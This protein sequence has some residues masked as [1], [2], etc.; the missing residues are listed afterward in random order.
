MLILVF[1]FLNVLL[2]IGIMYYDSTYVHMEKIYMQIGV[3]EKVGINVDSDAIYFGKVYPGGGSYRKIKI[4]NNF[5]IPLQAEIKLEGNITP[6]VSV[7]QNNFIIEPGQ[8]EDMT[9]YA[10][11]KTNSLYGNYTGNATVYYTRVL[12]FKFFN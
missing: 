2:G 12:P 6:F 4:T 7:S 10:K 11:T 5:E 8:S 3:A 1:I 9:F